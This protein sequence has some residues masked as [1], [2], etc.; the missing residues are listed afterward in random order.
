MFSTCLRRLLPCPVVT[1]VK[2]ELFYKSNAAI[3]GFSCVFNRNT[4]VSVDFSLLLSM[5]RTLACCS[6]VC[7]PGAVKHCKSQQLVTSLTGPA[8]SLWRLSAGQPCLFTTSSHNIHLSLIL[9]TLKRS[10]V[11]LVDRI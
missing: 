8:P 9:Y 5:F 1:G 11:V 7:P 4:A 6:V 2:A 10:F 3:Q